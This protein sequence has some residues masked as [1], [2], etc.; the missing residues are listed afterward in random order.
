M[1][2]VFVYVFADMKNCRVIFFFILLPLFSNLL[3]L[4]GNY[5]FL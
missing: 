4:M 3:F 1:V 5:L 2:F